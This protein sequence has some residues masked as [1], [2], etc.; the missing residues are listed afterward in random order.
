MQAASIDAA[1]SIYANLKAA[2]VTMVTVSELSL[3]SGGYQPGHA[4]CR[5]RSMPQQGFN[6]K[7]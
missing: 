4:Y 2:G 1:P 5:G 7:G 3:N 6:C